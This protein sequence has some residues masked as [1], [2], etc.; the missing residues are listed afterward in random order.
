MRSISSA[1]LG[2]TIARRML[3]WAILVPSIIG[4]FRLYGQRQ[5]LYNTEFGLILHA[6]SNIVIFSFIIWRNGRQ[7]DVLDKERIQASERFKLVVEATPSGLIMVNSSGQV[8]LANR[9]AEIY[10]GYTKA[11][12]LG[13]SIEL[14]LPQRFRGNH[15]DF[16]KLFF[17]NPQARKMGVGRELFGRRKDGSEFPVEIGLNPLQ[18]N[19]ETVALSSIIDISA[20]KLAEEKLSENENR[21]RQLADSMPQLVWTAR[22]DGTIEYSN[23]LLHEF[24]GLNYDDAKDEPKDDTLLNSIIH[25]D[26]LGPRSAAW[27]EAIRQGRPYQLEYRLKR[28]GAQQF[29]WFLDRAIPSRDAAGNIARWYA[30]TTDIDDLKKAQEA[31]ARFN[32]ELEMAV[33]SKTAELQ[34]SVSALNTANKELDS[35]SYSVSH[36]LRAPLRAIDGFSRI[37]TEEHATELS[38]D[39]KEYLERVRINTQKMG[40]LVDDLLAFSRLGRQPL[41]KTPSEMRGIVLQVLDDLKEDL[42]NRTIDIR[43]LELPPCDCDPSLLKQVWVNLITN[44]LKFSRKKNPAII[45]IGSYLSDRSGVRVYFVKDNGV[46]FDMKFSNKL[47]GVFQR[48]HRA[49]DFEGTGVGLAIAQRVVQRHGGKIWAE[50][51]VGLGATFYF[52]V[53]GESEI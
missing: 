14:L 47:F 53:E 34:D 30:T 26:D 27:R 46:G 11:E 28:K 42:K 21:Y 43:L 12:L 50:A 48:M 8:L 5:G 4:W 1:T 6:L 44:A 17:E 9:Q 13:Q 29:R 15:P 24:I 37:L 51:E 18:L 41:N 32:V 45:E 19:G 35:F 20:R 10:F 16:R 2:G 33:K 38:T 31:I 25:P 49:E 39:A 22:A 3:P 52:T 40:Q 7:I 23:R 36:D